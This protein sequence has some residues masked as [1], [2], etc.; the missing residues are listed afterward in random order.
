MGSYKQ[1][2]KKLDRPSLCPGQILST[3][4]HS[5]YHFLF[6]LHL[7]ISSVFINNKTVRF[8]VNGFI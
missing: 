5:F 7:D 3:V 8:K 1:V 4:R 6:L 2:K